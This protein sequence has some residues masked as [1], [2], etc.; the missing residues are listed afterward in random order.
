MRI[1]KRAQQKTVVQV[2]QQHGVSELACYDSELSNPFPCSVHM[3]AGSA[4]TSGRIRIRAMVS[5]GC[6]RTNSL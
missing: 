3:S 1:N 4:L 5:P 2:V 6:L